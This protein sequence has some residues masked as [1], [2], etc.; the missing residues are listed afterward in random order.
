V[1][2]FQ[3]TDD[4]ADAGID[5]FFGCSCF[6]P[7][8]ESGAMLAKVN[9][10]KAIDKIRFSSSGKT[11]WSSPAYIVCCQHI[12]Q[13]SWLPLVS[14]SASACVTRRHQGRVRVATAYFRNC[15]HPQVKVVMAHAQLG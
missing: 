13:Q 11:N 6:G 5:E 4:D 10:T 14:D 8:F 2:R 1:T 7:S 12:G 15:S 3:S 9:A